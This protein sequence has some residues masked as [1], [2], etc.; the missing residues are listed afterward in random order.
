[1]NHIDTNWKKTSIWEAHFY[2]ITNCSLK[3]I[4]II[5][6]SEAQFII[7]TGGC[8]VAVSEERQSLRFEFSICNMALI[9]NKLQN[10]KNYFSQKRKVMSR[11]LNSNI[12]Q[13][14]VFTELFLKIRILHSCFRY[15]LLVSQYNFVSTTIFSGSEKFVCFIWQTWVSFMGQN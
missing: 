12:V 2:N 11:I 9:N 13:P 6:L 1:M 5:S 4:K 15:L 3:V 7:L 8:P 14:M 10:S